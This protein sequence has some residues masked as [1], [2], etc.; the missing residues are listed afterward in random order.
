VTAQVTSLAVADSV[1]VAGLKN[2]GIVRSTDGG[3]NW[4]TAKKGPFNPTVN[5]LVTDGR[6][7]FA[8]TGA[9]G[10]GVSQLGSGIFLSTDSGTTWDTANVNNGLPW[11]NINT[12]CI[13]DTFLIAGA[14]DNFGTYSYSYVRPLSEMVKKDSTSRVVNGPSAVADTI[15]IYPNPATGLV[16]I[17][18]EG[19]S[20]LGVSV[21]NVLGSETGAGVRGSGSGEI[22]LDLSKLPSG[23]YFLQIE[24]AK[25][26]VMRKI[27]RK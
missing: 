12:L 11:P 14:W 15:E 7:F 5:S 4:V 13:F 17:N 24:T 18:S 19:I 9:V 23:T 22:S 1:I 8:G 26:M 16:T 27:V 21:M 2:N 25:G 20:I 10:Q 3:A 6:N